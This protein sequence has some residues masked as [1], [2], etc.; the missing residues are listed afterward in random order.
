MSDGNVNVTI[1]GIEEIKSKWSVHSGKIYKTTI[2]LPVTG[3]RDAITGNSSLLANQVFVDGKMMM[4]ARWPNISNSEDL[5]NR[6]DFRPVPKEDWIT[7]ATLTDSAI[8]DISGGWTGGTIWYLGWYVPNSGTIISSSTGQIKFLSNAIGNKRDYYYLTGRLGA[9]DAE[10]EW[11]YDGTYIYLWAPGGSSP[12]NVDVK[13]R[14]YAFDLSDKSYITISN[15]SVFAATITT[16]SNSTNVTLDRLRVQYNSHYVTIQPGN[17]TGAH[18]TET[19]VRLAGANSIIKNSLIEY[20]AGQGI[21]LGA[22]G[23]TAENNLVHDIS[24][25]GTYSCGIMP[26]RDN[27]PQTITH[28]TIYRT[29]RSGIDGIGSNKDIGYNDI[30]D[31]GLLNTDL[32]AIYSAN[33]LNLTG[34]SIHHN[35]LH[36]AKNDNTHTYPVG[37]G[38]YLDQDAKPT[39]I[40][41][42]VFWNNNKNDIRIQQ[43]FPPY[44]KIYNNT[45]ASNPADF[46][47]SF[48]S[49]K[50][51]CPDNSKNNIYSL[52]IKPNTPGSNE[53]TSKTNPLFVDPSAGGLGF[54]LKPGSPAID[55]GAEIKGI[56]D[57]FKGKATDIGAYEYGGTEWRAGVLSKPGP[58][59]SG[60]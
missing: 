6:A 45:L 26:T 12:A 52:L 29:G 50:A 55:A 42:N 37:A 13:M 20:S 2:A 15:I 11:F 14:N 49:Y 60:P 25:G 32:G 34:T 22:A 3:Y 56:T 16:N 30:Y 54:R 46:W 7:G 57:G 24:Y 33:G 44:N 10:K 35:W 19:G 58:V 38:I 21:V 36:D 8:P 31:F 4:E 27:S 51:S 41:H 48:H 17:S 9:L 1:S 40:D 43:E 23:C 28:N 18:N 47:F 39:L 53:I 59:L 5:L